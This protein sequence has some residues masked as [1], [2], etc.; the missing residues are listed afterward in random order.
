[1][2]ASYSIQNNVTVDS[3]CS[4]VQN[5]VSLIKMLLNVDRSLIC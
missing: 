4:R 3:Y 5:W 1:M 2:Y